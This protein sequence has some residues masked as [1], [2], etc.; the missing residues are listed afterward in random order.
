LPAEHVAAV[1]DGM[2]LAELMLKIM[3]K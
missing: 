3:G 1:F 2:L